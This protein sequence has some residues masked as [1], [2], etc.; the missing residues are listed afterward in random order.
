MHYISI[1]LEK[2]YQE[3]EMFP[4]SQDWIICMYLY[5][6]LFKCDRNGKGPCFDRIPGVPS[7]RQRGTSA[8]RAHVSALC[9]GSA[10]QRLACLHLNQ[11]VGEDREGGILLRDFTKSLP[12]CLFSYTYCLGD[13]Q[14]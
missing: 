8:G 1:K 12:V 7:P 10:G 9:A 11:A 13:N 2:N 5:G 14:V 3:E 4:F 6:K